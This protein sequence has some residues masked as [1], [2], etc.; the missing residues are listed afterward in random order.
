MGRRNYGQGYASDEEIDWA[1]PEGVPPNPI[2]EDEEDDQAD[3]ERSFRHE[4]REQMA[5]A[6]EEAPHVNRALF[7]DDVEDDNGILARDYVFTSQ[8]PSQ[9]RVDEDPVC[10]VEEP[11][12]AVEGPV[13]DAPAPARVFFDPNWVPGDAV[14]AAQAISRVLRARLRRQ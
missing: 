5:S 14:A 11:V 12:G 1:A 10:V 7:G 8:G 6:E 9:T 13:A 2:S 3:K 4:V